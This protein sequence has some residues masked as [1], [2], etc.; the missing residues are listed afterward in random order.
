MCDEHV[1]V[2]GAWLSRA[3]LRKAR[4]ELPAALASSSASHGDRGLTSGERRWSAPPKLRLSLV[5]LRATVSLP[6]HYLRNAFLPCPHPRGSPGP[7]LYTQVRTHPG[8][9]PR[10]SA[11]PLQPCPSLD[12]GLSARR[13]ARPLRCGPWS[14][15]WAP[16]CLMGEHKMVS[17]APGTGDKTSCSGAAPKSPMWCPP[18]RPEHRHGSHIG[19]GACGPRCC[20][21]ATPNSTG[22]PGPA[23][24]CSGEELG[25]VGSPGGS[26]PAPA[27]ALGLPCSRPACQRA[28]RKELVQS[29]RHRSTT[30]ELSIH[31]TPACSRSVSLSRPRP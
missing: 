10:P 18:P 7:V 29:P 24:T 28:A 22:C 11:P 8:T 23:H 4:T 30:E 14:S 9:H 1:C 21:A 6:R 5:H 19:K 20:R 12:A 15:S 3:C 31:S 16:L 25:P 26:S 2:S 17:C 13:G 27:C